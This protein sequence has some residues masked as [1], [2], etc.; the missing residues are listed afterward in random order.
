MA[1]NGDIESMKQFLSKTRALLSYTGSGIGHSALHWSCA[2]G[3]VD[4]AK[5]LLD[6][7]CDVNIRNASQSTPL[8]AAAGNG[9]QECVKMLLTTPSI[10]IFLRDEDGNTAALLARK[11]KFLAI[12]TLINQGP[13]GTQDH[14]AC[15][16][17]G[18]QATRAVE[19][20]LGK[21]SGE[22]KQVA[23]EPSESYWVHVKGQCGQPQPQS[24]SD[25][26]DKTGAQVDTLQAKAQQA[27]ERGN[28]AFTKGEYGKASTQYSMAIRLDPGNH[29]Y[30]SN[31][32]GAYCA[33]GNF[34][35][36]LEDANTCIKLKP[37]WAKGYSRKGAALVGMGQAGEGVKS[38]LR[39][40]QVEPNNQHARDG[41]STA[42]AAI[43][44]H[45]QRYKDMWGDT[46]AGNTS[47]HEEVNGTFLAEAMELGAKAEADAEETLPSD[48]RVPAE[49]P[50]KREDQRKD[51][52]GGCQEATNLSVDASSA[53]LEA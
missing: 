17:D 46:G 30:I 2:K 22:T 47:S 34:E 49:V 31:R 16:L 38:Y 6:E 36:A 14:V 37:D 5:W 52:G 43:R 23:G 29:L 50:C 9:Q 8:H 51:P 48:L 27:K 40:L 13:M 26:A 41:L 33:M 1:K 45:Q 44:A 7:G 20:D 42:K 39:A 12:E 10:D 25:P 35:K 32:S 21:A 15:V 24:A 19:P 11:R 18:L 53:P 28:E 4:I 3:H